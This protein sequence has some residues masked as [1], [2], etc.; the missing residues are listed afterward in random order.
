MGYPFCRPHPAAGAAALQLVCCSPGRAATGGDSSL[1]SLSLFSTPSALQHRPL[2]PTPK[3]WAATR[4]LA[5]SLQ[6]SCLSGP[7]LLWTE[8]RLCWVRRYQPCVRDRPQPR[9][10]PLAIPNTN[11]PAVLKAPKRRLKFEANNFSLQDQVAGLALCCL[12][13][14]WSHFP[15]L[16]MAYTPRTRTLSLN[17]G[18]NLIMANS[19]Y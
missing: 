18:S 9:R 13:L 5:L 6:R 12:E 3:S 2:H 10:N 7:V 15:G 8:W 16:E 19:G 17:G 1:A 4:V 11:H 14:A